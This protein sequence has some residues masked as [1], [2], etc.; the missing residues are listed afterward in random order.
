M[1][2]SPP[3]DQLELDLEQDDLSWH[4]WFMQLPRKPP[5]KPPSQPQEHKA[6]QKR[7]SRP[8]G[9]G[10]PQPRQNAA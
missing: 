4:D 7:A 2:R 1:S 8:R 5:S 3:S 10:S 9:A 6:R